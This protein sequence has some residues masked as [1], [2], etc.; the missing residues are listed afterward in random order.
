MLVSVSFKKK[1]LATATGLTLS[2]AAV[3]AEKDVEVLHWWTSGGEAAALSV[4]KDDLKT[5]GFGW[6][7]MPI[8]GGGGDNAKTVLRARVVGGNAPTAV[9]MLGFSIQDWAAEDA[10]SNLNKLAK[11]EKWDDKVPP[12]VQQFSKYNG[13]WVAA[14]VNIHRTNWVWANKKIFDELNLEVPQSFA[15]L[16]AISKKISAAGYIPLAHGGQAWQEATIFDSVVLSVGGP[17][18]YRK[19]FYDLDESALSSATMAEVFDQMRALRGMVD[20]NFPGRD[21]NLATSMVIR[22][23]AAMQIMG[24]WAKGEFLNAKKVPNEDFLCFQYPGT[25][26]MFSFNSD[27]FA[28]FEVSRKARKGQ[29]AMAASVMDE[30]FQEQ[31]NLVKGSIPAN[32][33]VKP[34]SFE[35]CGQKSMADLKDAVKSDTMVGSIAHG[36]AVRADI[37]GVIYDVVTNH[38]NNTKMTSKQA[39][40]TLV[41]TIK[42]VM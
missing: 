8:A 12:A 22:G 10:L 7:D 33:N 35:S 29:E 11:K 27:Q 19:A 31:F 21:W 38:F 37:Q 25:E 15:E 20:D 32:M 13:Q 36:H 24:D 16:L 40:N 28:M 26:G 39:V 14:P 6:K 9:Q 2:V 17:E 42:G 41:S 1:L 30:G 5:K 23:E 3:S 4:L 18:F 34:D